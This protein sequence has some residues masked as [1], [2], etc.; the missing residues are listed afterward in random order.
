MVLNYLSITGADASKKVPAYIHRLF[1]RPAAAGLPALLAGFLTLTSCSMVKGLFSREKTPEMSLEY[2]EELRLA[3]IDRDIDALRE[4][5]NIFEDQNQPLDIRIAAVRAVGE[6]R[7]PL[8][9]ESLAAYVREAEALELDLME[10]SIAVLGDFQDDPRASGALVESIF[11][12]DEKLKGLQKVVFDNLKNVDMEDQVLILLDIYERSRANF[13]QTA[14]MVSRTLAKMDRDEVI[15]VLIFIANDRSLDINIR[16]RALDVLAQKKQSPEVVTMFVDM[17]TDPT[18]EGQIRDFALRTM[19][20]VKEENLILA[21]L[22]SYGQGRKS[23]FS[24]L[25]TLLDALGN[26]DD[27]A[28][29]P[30]LVEIALTPDV[31]RPLR[32]KA[33]QNLANFDDPKVVGPIVV[34]LE[35]AKNYE[36]YPHIVELARRLGVEEEVKDQLR[37][38]ALVAQEK[39][40]ESK[41]TAP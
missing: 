9:L 14:L 3:Y 31:P 36:F 17:L 37:R 29:K 18:L 8:A 4:L 24:L 16:N 33:I 39:A 40:I 13:N 28:V 19:K 25:N 27:P 34:L 41:D 38:A 10:A 5:I 1:F 11:S 15:P 32:I 20:D 6:S 23:Y 35:E 21:L 2:V 22:E 26:F 12:I 7:H 30:V